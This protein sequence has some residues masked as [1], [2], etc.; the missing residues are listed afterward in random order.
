MPF[1]RR[2]ESTATAQ[3]PGF[4]PLIVPYDTHYHKTQYMAYGTKLDSDIWHIS[5]FSH[6][7]WRYLR[8]NDKIEMR[9]FS[10]DRTLEG[11]VGDYDM[12]LFSFS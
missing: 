7:I 9:H 4:P 1:P 3:S 2:R 5:Y 10:I 11:F 12:A 8:G 6:A